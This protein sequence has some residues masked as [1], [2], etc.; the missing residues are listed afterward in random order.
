MPKPVSGRTT[1]LRSQALNHCTLS[2]FSSPFFLL[3][4]YQRL[5]RPSPSPQVR[6]HTFWGFGATQEADLQRIRPLGWRVTVSEISQ[7]QETSWT[8]CNKS[9]PSFLCDFTP[10][11]YS[12]MT[13]LEAGRRSPLETGGDLGRALTSC[14]CFPICLMDSPGLP[15]RLVIGILG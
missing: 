7:E 13:H 8:A 15:A 11:Q 3:C 10:E 6:S 9:K 2:L 5:L 14:A 1:K 12:R 4:L